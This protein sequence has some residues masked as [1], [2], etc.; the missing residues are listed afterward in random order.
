MVSDFKECSVMCVYY[1]H[2]YK[3]T[4]ID[5]IIK[6]TT[7][8]LQNTEEGTE[9]CLQALGNASEVLTLKLVLTA[10]Y[11]ID[12]QRKLHVSAHRYER[13]W[14]I[15]RKSKILRMLLPGIIFFVLF[16]YFHHPLPIW[17]SNCLDL[18]LL[19]GRCAFDLSPPPLP[20]VSQ[21]QGRAGQAQTE[22]TLLMGRD[23]LLNRQPSYLQK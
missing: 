15:W 17:L 10:E 14:C 19:L 13:V 9:N 11:V 23:D 22:S 12:R 5:G 4:V 1:I 8:G 16:L 21:P 20:A 7:K 18:K 3:Y 6:T 2:V